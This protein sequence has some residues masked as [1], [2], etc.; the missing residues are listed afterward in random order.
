MEDREA[1]KA[2][3]AKPPTQVA[4]PWRAVVRTL[5]QMAVGLAVVLPLAFSAATLHDPEEATGWFG[6]ALAV[7]GAVTRV[8]ALPVVDGFLD[9]WFPWLAA[10]PAP[11]GHDG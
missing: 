8:M 4:R 10:A 6:V 3:E 7:A 1:A 9:R 11:R 5:F 2:T